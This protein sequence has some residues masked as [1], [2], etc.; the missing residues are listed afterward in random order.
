MVALKG[1]CYSLNFY[2]VLNLIS[3]F[4]ASS[5]N[6]IVIK[7]L[8]INRYLYKTQHSPGHWSWFTA[9][10]DHIIFQEDNHIVYRISYLH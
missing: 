1:V 10:Q 7:L 8:L 4:F 6:F 5:I 3:L 9:G 2:L